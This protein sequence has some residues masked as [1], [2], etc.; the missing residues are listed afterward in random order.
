MSALVKLDKTGRVACCPLVISVEYAPRA[1]LRLGKD[2]TDRQMDAGP[3]HYA[4]R[5][6]RVHRNNWFVAKKTLF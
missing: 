4:Y 3:L 6:R 2:G 1:L 5:Y